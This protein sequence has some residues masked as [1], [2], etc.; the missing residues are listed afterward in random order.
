MA[1]AG[2]PA[3]GSI[4]EQ[5]REALDN[6]DAAFARADAALSRQDLATYGKQVK[7]AQQF[8]DEALRLAEQRQG[9]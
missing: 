6:A 5:I 1:R 9:S 4:N 7:R 2:K 3:T 8:V